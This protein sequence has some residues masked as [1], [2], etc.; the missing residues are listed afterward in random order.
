MIPLIQLILMVVQ[1]YYHLWLNGYLRITD[2]SNPSADFDCS[3]KLQMDFL[4]F[5][6]YLCPLYIQFYLL[7][8]LYPPVTHRFTRLSTSHNQ[9]PSF[10]LHRKDF[11]LREIQEIVDEISLF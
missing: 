4:G 5:I 11:T 10:F 2:S 7:S 9:L 1:F 8:P 6:I 3:D